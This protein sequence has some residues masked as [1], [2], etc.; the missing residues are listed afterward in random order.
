MSRS[1]NF[2]V[3]RYD[4]ITG[5]Y[6][7]QHPLIWNF[8][9]T[10]RVPADL[11]PYN[12]CHDLFNIVEERAYGAYPHM[13]GIHAGL[14][15]NCCQEIID[16]FDNNCCTKEKDGYDNKPNVRWFTYA[17]MYLYILLHKE[18]MPKESYIDTNGDEIETGE[19][20]TNPIEALKERVDAFLDVMD[21]WDWS[22]AYSEIRIVY[23]ID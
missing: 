6:E 5:K 15:E 8:D 10:K 7:L 21:W 17:D 18:D 13:Q 19:V 22:D 4:F 2:F 16:N 12:G 14:P 3:E 23:W 1:P 11:F 20:L 9:H